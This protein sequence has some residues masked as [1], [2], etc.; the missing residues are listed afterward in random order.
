MD[1]YQPDNITY[2]AEQ[3]NDLMKLELDYE[4]IP[5]KL[6]GCMTMI[7]NKYRTKMDEGQ[8]VLIV[9]K[10]GGE[11]NADIILQESTHVLA[12]ENRNLTMMELV[13]AMTKKF[14]LMEGGDKT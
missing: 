13:K 4:E 5:K 8:Q 3:L 11:Q 10:C 6:G 14:C 12:D 1:E 7:I 9:P 2:T